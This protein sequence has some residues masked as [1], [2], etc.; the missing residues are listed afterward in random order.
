MET[1]LALVAGV[2]VSSAVWLMLSGN[3]L[4]FLFGLLLLSNG[5]NVAIFAAGR[6]TEAAAPLL[7][8]GGGVPEQAMAN[9]LPQA[10]LLT[11]IV[12]GFGLFA[13][14][15]ALAIRAYRSFGHLE[16]DRMRLAEPEE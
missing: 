9:A 16:V 7:T 10:L 6:L 14:A 1:V 12:I 13:F 3:L 5:V 2:L 8:N 11:A 15:L 4:R